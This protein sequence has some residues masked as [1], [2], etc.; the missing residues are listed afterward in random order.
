MSERS[1]PPSLKRHVE[2]ALQ[3]ECSLPRQFKLAVAVSGGPDSMALCDVLCRLRDSMDFKLLALSLNHDLRK[4]AAEEVSLVE[5]FCRDREIPFATRS[6]GLAPGSNLQERARDS[7]YRA[8]WEL[9]IQH[10]G[11]DVYLATAHHK[12]DRAETVLLRILRGTSIEGLDVF[13][14]QQDRLLRPMIRASRDDV[15]RHI[16]RHEIPHV[17]DPS[18]QDPRFLRVRVRHEL[19]P[20]LK[21]LGPGVVSHLEALADDAAGLL[22]PGGL[23]REQREQLRT[24]LKNPHL[25]LDLP[26]SAGIRLVRE[27]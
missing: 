25:G 12:D 26:L 7:R 16:A 4:E 10:F 27:R 23:N 8:L 22:E 18:N 2:R 9:A 21:E 5:K 17:M 1:H 13:K 20:L 6:L 3:K 19:L 24:A 14:A 11:Q 15:E